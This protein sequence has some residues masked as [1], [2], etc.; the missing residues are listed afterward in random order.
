[1]ELESL[2]RDSRPSALASALPRGSA[3]A[4][5]GQPGKL[6]VTEHRR[7][8][9][10]FKD[11]Y[12]GWR[13]GLLL[14]FIASVVVLFFNL[15]FTLWAVQHRRLQGNQGV[16]YEGDCKKVGHAGV[17]LHFII[18]IFGT[19]LLGASNYCM[20]SLSYNGKGDLCNA[21]LWVVLTGHEA[22]SLCAHEKR[23]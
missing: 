23:Y 3:D 14:G 4:E 13:L 1:M 20:V 6:E 21:R 5:K 11:Q 10:K 2:Q 8:F 15:G 17:G 9:D 7:R 19:A 22:M 18:N 12:K 16:L